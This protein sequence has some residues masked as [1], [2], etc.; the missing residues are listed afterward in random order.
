MPTKTIIEYFMSDTQLIQA[1]Y[2]IVAFALARRNN[3]QTLR[4]SRRSDRLSKFM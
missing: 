2:L 1:G 4:Q 3:L